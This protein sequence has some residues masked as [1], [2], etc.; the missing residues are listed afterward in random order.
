MAT[1]HRPEMAEPKSLMAALRFNAAS[2]SQLDVPEVLGMFAKDSVRVRLAVLS[3]LLLAQL[4]LRVLALSAS[5]ATA[6]AVFLFA[7]AI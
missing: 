6:V 7:S 1:L 5:L 2:Q 3:A 4:S